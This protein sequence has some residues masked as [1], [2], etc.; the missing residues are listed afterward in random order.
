MDLTQINEEAFQRELTRRV[1]TGLQET[2]DAVLAQELPPRLRQLLCRLD[3]LPSRARRY[4]Q[5]GNSA[6]NANNF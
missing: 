4:S 6:G 1:G 3:S 2:Y 5:A